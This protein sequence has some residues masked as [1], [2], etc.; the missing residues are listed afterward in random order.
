MHVRWENCAGWWRHAV[1]GVA[2]ALVATLVASGS[3]WALYLDEDRNISLRLRAYAQA[4]MATQG[5]EVQSDPGK[6][7]G[8][9]VSQRNFFN[10]EFEIK[11]NPYV[12][13]WTGT[14]WLDE[15]S[16]RLA[17]WGFYDGYLDYGPQQYAN[18]AHQAKFHFDQ[19]GAPFPHGAFQTEGYSIEQ[20]SEGRGSRR[21]TRDVYAHRIRVNEA[22]VN[23]AKGP[24]FLRIGRQAISWGEADTIGLLDAN[25]PFDT[26]II[27]GVFLDLDEARIPLW[28]ARATYQLF[29]NAGPFSSGF[30]D[31]YIVPGMIDQTISPLQQQSVSPYSLPPP[32][33]NANTEV[34][35]HLPAW[36]FGNSRWGVRFQTVIARNY[37]T[38]VWFYKTFPTDPISVFRGLSPTTQRVNVSTEH[39]LTNV[40]GVATTFFF[41]PLNSIVRSEVEVF[42]NQPAFRVATN[43]RALSTGGQ[44]ASTFD[45]VNIIKGELGV[46]RNVFIRWLNPSN[47][48]IWVT[49]FV[50][51]YNPDETKFKDYRASGLLKP[52][53]IRREKEG[54]AQAGLGGTVIDPGSCDGGSG[55]CDYVNVSDFD[56]FIQTHLQ[57]DFMHGKLTPAITT[58]MSGTGALTFLPELSYRVTDYF[59]L[60]TK[61][62]NIHT[63]G[64]I[65]NG[66]G[67]GLGGVRDRDQIWL[68]ATYQL[69]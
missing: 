60:N 26:T 52:S 29:N 21:D 33:P 46:D 51:S 41:E 69:N 17:L 6:G 37:T 39:R 8:Q 40:A 18:R 27:P 65:N 5:S 47:S 19:N 58:I 9:F 45:K 63:F 3:A 20:L 55:K 67:A 30:L 34:F 36:K 42:N 54:G 23:I 25:N 64:S 68:R 12:E 14:S 49:A 28:T 50:F 10:P 38:S 53:A 44:Q 57:S 56:W 2:G 43:F 22:Y 32:A 66:F 35:D 15:F 31:T 16:G 24:L 48:F 1:R 7:V 11:F 62:V 13:S 4:S 61:Y 59:L